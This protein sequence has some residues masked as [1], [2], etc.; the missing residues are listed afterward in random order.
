MC[1]LITDEGLQHLSQ[2][3]RLRILDFTGCDLITDEGLRHI[4]SLKLTRLALCDCYDITDDGLQHVSKITSLRKLDIS[5]VGLTTDVGLVHVSKMA[6]LKYLDLTY[7][8]R[9]TCWG[10]RLLAQMLPNLRISGIKRTGA[11]VV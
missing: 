6:S 7:C 5:G 10:Q 11:K 1:E 8:N 3:L 4:S 2:S 9:I